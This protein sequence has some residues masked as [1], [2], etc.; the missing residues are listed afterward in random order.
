MNFTIDAKAL[1]GALKV[2]AKLTKGIKIPVLS[3]VRLAA[4]EH[5]TVTVIATD[6]DVACRISID[7]EVFQPGTV[8]LNCKALAAALPKKG[9]VTIAGDTVQ[10]GPFAVTV[11]SFAVADYPEVPMCSPETPLAAIET[12]FVGMI[13]RTVYCV[14]REVSR[15][16]LNGALLRILDR[17]VAMVATDGHRL[18]LA[19]SE[20]SYMSP[21]MKLVVPAFALRLMASCFDSERSV[22]IAKEESHVFFTCGDVQIVARPVAG[23]FPDYERVM[24][25]SNG[26]TLTVNRTALLDAVKVAEKNAPEPFRTIALK[27]NG[28]CRVEAKCDERK[29]AADVPAKWDG[30]E[31]WRVLVNA[32]YLREWLESQVCDTAVIR[33]KQERSRGKDGAILSVDSD[34]EKHGIACYCD[35]GVES[36]IMPQRM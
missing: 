28:C 14:S 17:K 22:Y 23:T 31:D 35:P 19:E 7:A 33:L 30:L 18:A 13:D 4:T 2:A 24:P 36:V 3:G 20:A 9:M 15:F 6:L 21:N 26:H 1:Q 34:V 10:A 5:G 32:S 16:T 8:V 12:G 29:F 25:R 11:P 27:L